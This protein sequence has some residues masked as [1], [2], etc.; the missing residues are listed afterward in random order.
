MFVTN[1][2]YATIFL[3][4]LRIYLHFKNTYRYWQN[5][6][7]KVIEPIFFPLGN[8]WSFIEKDKGVGYVLADWYN[9]VDS[10]VVGMY[11]FNE[12]ILLVKVKKLYDNSNLQ[13][14]AKNS[15]FWNYRI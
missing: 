15:N 2:L 14:P 13:N 7:L 10:E 12:P 5:R 9:A 8:L 6:G 1:I 4:L 3:I 11:A